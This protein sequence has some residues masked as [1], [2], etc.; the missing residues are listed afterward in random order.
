MAIS[1]RALLLSS[2]A[3]AAAVTATVGV[4][5]AS[6]SAKSF[7]PVVEAQN[8]SKLTERQAIYLTPQY[9]AL[10]REVST[11]NTAAAVAMQAADPGRTFADDLCWNGNDGC[12]GDVRL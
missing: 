3:A 9:Q 11:Q 8:Y 1:R 4:P 5:L 12:A 7:N 2:V 10:L 6:A